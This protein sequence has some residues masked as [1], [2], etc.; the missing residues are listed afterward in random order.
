M[1]SRLKT[2][3]TA[4][5]TESSTTAASVPA[6]SLESIDQ[7]SLS[8]QETVLSVL[9]KRGRAVRSSPMGSPLSSDDSVLSRR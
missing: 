7:A 2:R 8:A 1:A 4:G 5:S 6:R 9:R 3:A